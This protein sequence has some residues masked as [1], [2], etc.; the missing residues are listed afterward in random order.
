MFAR[1]IDRN[2]WKFGSF[3]KAL[4]EESSGIEPDGKLRYHEE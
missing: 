2:M 4:Y 1:I 3:G